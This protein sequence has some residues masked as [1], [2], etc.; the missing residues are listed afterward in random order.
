[1]R[2]VVD[3]NIWVSAVISPKGAPARVLQAYRDGRFTLVTSETLLDEIRDVLN[4]PRI[5]GKYGIQADDVDALVDLMRQ[6][7]VLVTTTG[8]VHVCR[9][10]DDDESIEVAIVGQADVVVSRDEDLARAPE[11]AEYLA[12]RGVR[13]LTVRRFLDELG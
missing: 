10:P 3:T 2:A 6:R 4:R 7:A 12:G 5:A 11:V 8:A 1:V 9:D 13:T